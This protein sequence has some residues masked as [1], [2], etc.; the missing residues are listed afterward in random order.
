MVK[1]VVVAPKIKYVTNKDLLEEIHKSKITY[2]S[3]LDEQH[4]S[5][6]VIVYDLEEITPEKLLE[7]R[8]KKLATLL[9]LEKKKSKISSYTPI[10]YTI[11][12][13]S[14]ESIVIRLMTYSHIPPH[15][16]KSETGKTVSERHVRCNFPPFQHYILK[17]NK[18]VC[19]LKS[20]WKGGLENGYFSKDHG[21]MTNKLAMMFMKLVERYGH[22]GNWRGYCV[23]ENTY[24]MTKDGWK[25]IDEISTKDEILSYNLNTENM[26][27]S[28]IKSIFKDQFNGKMFEY[29]T[30]DCDMLITPG[31]K[32]VTTDGLK[33][34]EYLTTNDNIILCGKRLNDLKNKIYE[35]DLVEIISVMFASTNGKLKD[36]FKVVKIPNSNE[37]SHKFLTLCKNNSIDISSIYI[38]GCNTYVTINQNIKDYMKSIFPNNKMNSNLFNSLTYNQKS[39]FL[40]TFSSFTEN[41]KNIENIDDVSFTVKNQH[42]SDMIQQLLFLTGIRSNVEII[43]K[44]LNNLTFKITSIKTNENTCKVSTHYTTLSPVDT[45]EDKIHTPNKPTYLYKGR[46]WC[47]ETEYGCFVALRNGTTYLT[48]N[49]YNDEMKGQA[50]LQLS[51]VGLQFNESKGDNPFA[52]LTQV[53]STSFMRV[54]NLEKR[55]QTIRDDILIMNGASPS[56]T[57]QVSDQLKQQDDDT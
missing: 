38:K 23:D 10:E 33:R 2:C 47:P 29:K 19:V 15:P 5:Y 35:D 14:E 36:R 17:D 4:T 40:K 21:K 34:I 31:H 7:V 18:L 53:V 45:T 46:V 56:F 27:W 22:R 6:D 48:G 3:Y 28:S 41:S 49:T 16:D 57:R 51:Q 1:N 13:I 52:Y 9:Q 32:L 26:T 42:D 50:L 20:H 43:Q 11:D 44:K 8:Q 30:N 12:D 25:G 24:A 54:L 37:Y 55:S 39:L